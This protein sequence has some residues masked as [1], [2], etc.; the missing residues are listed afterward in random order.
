MAAALGNNHKK[1]TRKRSEKFM[2][3]NEEKYRVLVENMLDGVAV[4]DFKGRIL[5]FNDAAQRMLEIDDPDKWI[6]RS[7][8]PLVFDESKKAV[9]SDMIRVRLGRGGYFQ[10]YKL[11]TAKGNILWVENIGKKIVYAGHPVIVLSF[12]NINERVETE[13]ILDVE[14][15]KL[16][17]LNQIISASNT[18]YKLIDL[19]KIVLLSTIKT[20]GYFGGGIYLVNKKNNTAEVVASIKLNESFLKSVREV[21]ISDKPYYTVFIKGEPIITEHYERI[22]PSGAKMSGIKSL[23]SVPL[24]AGNEIIGALNVASKKSHTVSASDKEVL[25]SISRELGS[26]IKKFQAEESLFRSEE[27][28][29]TILENTLDIIYSFDSKG[30]IIFVSPNVTLW[31]YRVEDVVGSNILKF[32]HKDDRKKILFEMQKTID[33]GELFTTTFRLIKSDGTF[34]YAEEYGKPI[35]DERRRLMNFTGIIRDITERKMA[36][37]EL[38]NTNERLRVMFEDAPDAYYLSDLKGTIING[39]KEAE[40]ITGYDRRELIGSR[41]INLRELVAPGQKAKILSLLAKNIKGESTGPDEF[42]LVKK[43][44]TS[45][46]VEIS[47]HPVK[48]DG[49]SMVLGIARDITSRKIIENELRKE[50]DFSQNILDTS[51]VVILV[52]DAEGNVVSINPYFEKISGYKIDEVKGVNWFAKFLPDRDRAKI[53]NVFLSVKEGTPV[54][55]LINSILTKS[56]SEISIEWFNQVLRDESGKIIGVLST[57]QDVT[58]RL[59]TEE[60]IRMSEE[61]FSKAFETSPYAKIMTRPTDGKIIDANEAL[62]K[63]SGY[64]RAE[65]I[66]K[67]T[68][69]L[70]LWVNFNERKKIVDDL[71]NG[72]SVKNREVQFRKKSGEIIIGNFF[73]DLV[74]VGNEKI[75]LSSI[76]DITEKKKASEN[77]RLSEERYR[78]VVDNATESIVVVQDGVFKFFNRQVIQVTGF[79]EKEFAKKSFI[80]IIHPDDR[81][82]VAE[83]H[84]KRLLG[85]KLETPYTFRIIDKSG[86]V[87]WVEIN[88]VLIMWAGRPATL[89][90][91]KDVTKRKQVEDDLQKRVVEVEKTKKAMMNVLEDIE[92]EK[93]VSESLAKDLE[94]FKLAVEGASD[95]IVITDAEAKI[96][97]ANKATEKITGFKVDEIIGFDPGELWG[98]QMSKDFY[99]KMWQTI[100]DEKK[101]YQGELKNKRKDGEIYDAE[102]HISPVFD[103]NGEII[104]FLSIEKDITRAKEIDRMKTEFVSIASHQLRTPLTSMK[105]YTELLLSDKKELTKKQ[106]DY[107][108]RIYSGSLKMVRLVNDLLNV[109]RIE[110]GKK[111]AIEKKKSDI[112]SIVRRV[113]S[114]QSATVVQN[115]VKIE[116]INWPEHLLMMVDEEKLYQVFQNLINNAVRY[117]NPG[118]KIKVETKPGTG[119]NIFIVKDIG[120]GIPL[121][122]QN[123]IYEKFFR[124]DN[125]TNSGKAGTGLGLYIVKAIVEGHGGKIWFESGEN[126]GTTFYFELPK[127]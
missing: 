38:K 99:Q 34:F 80:E 79:S 110:T 67:T 63:L 85:E 50:R 98:G 100:K 96:L 120:M 113:I 17:L 93:N 16:S 126:I 66:G 76:D 10:R 27:R 86:N 23:V 47:T 95:L 4:V 20:L 118:G 19:L 46:F 29:R 117:S 24:V 87:K 42:T 6:N 61:K 64:S 108:H 11:L 35:F 3:G 109:S 123:R 112:T 125:V 107:V 94:K 106:T 56:G 37:K 30:K 75:V 33:S 101:V 68:E 1:K 74:T 78:N 45:I 7:L 57:G 103:D 55:G 49:K 84:Q 114:D 65:V 12:R 82:M 43:D 97:F 102:V 36:E 83:R 52:L 77:L 51:Q 73:A 111:F 127:K 72:I 124:A 15:R 14:R 121:K 71:K 48:I 25:F 122:Q 21:K 41:F 62:F 44:R 60:K 116:L 28:Y 5:M 59:L 9:L 18:S 31:G 81:K 39:N 40:K 69:E 70:T 2:N 54:R 115:D 90:F 88:A 32:V 22:S 104:F 91:L 92:K 13:H 89:N 8:L 53:K 58:S 119:S 26:A 105:W